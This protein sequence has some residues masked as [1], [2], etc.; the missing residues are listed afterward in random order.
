MRMR[1]VLMLAAVYSERNRSCGNTKDL[2][3]K[4]FERDVLAHSQKEEGS[5]G[6]RGVVN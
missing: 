2:I 1:R 3:W 4:R 6:A 5:T